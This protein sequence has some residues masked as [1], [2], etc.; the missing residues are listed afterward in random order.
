RA[1]ATAGQ[2]LPPPDDPGA[3]VVRV[4]ELY[5]RAWEEGDVDAIVALLSVDARYS[6]PPLQQWFAGRDA[7]RGF[8]LDAP[9]R[10]RWRFLVGRS[11]EQ[12]AFGTY[13]WDT[14]R[15]TF[16]AVSLDLIRVHGGEITEV[17]SFLTPE[18]LGRFGFPEEVS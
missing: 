2:R 18:I 5:V 3:D 10:H 1:R 14:D 9:L 6:M 12:V 7:I 17:V 15:G 8:I 11:N 13:A 16:V 4:A